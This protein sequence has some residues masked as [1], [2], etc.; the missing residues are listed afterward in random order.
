MLNRRTEWC[1]ECQ[2]YH[3]QGKH[4]PMYEVWSDDMGVSQ[5]DAGQ[6]HADDMQDAAEK[7][8][9]QDDC[10][11]GDY[12]ILSDK[13]QPVVFVRRDGVTKSYRVFAESIP[14]YRATEMESD[15]SA[16]DEIGFNN[17]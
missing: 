9:E 16:T 2:K 17:D 15:Y 12:M 8:A 11:S 1:Q 14:E 3:I 7:W 10:N 4:S 13:M 5:D 6:L